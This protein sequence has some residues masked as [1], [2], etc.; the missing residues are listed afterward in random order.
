MLALLSKSSRRAGGFLGR[1][2]SPIGLDLG[3]HAIRAVQLTRAAGASG[4]GETLY[5]IH[6]AAK[7]KRTADPEASPAQFD[8]R[9]AV[10]LKRMLDQGGFKGRKLVMGLDPP[11]LVA[12][13]ISLP[14]K[15]KPLDDP[16]VRSALYFE[17]S[18]HIGYEA[19]EAEIRAWPLPKGGPLA[20]TVM[21]VAARRQVV[22][23]WY[24]LAASAGYSCRRV[25]SGACALVRSCSEFCKP[26]PDSIWGV[27]DVGLLAARLV[28]AVHG[29]PVLQR[30]LSTGG[31]IL[32]YR[33][34]EHLRL[35]PQAAERL[36]VDHGIAGG[37][38][39][40]RDARAPVL[41]ADVSGAAAPS[42]D[43]SS[44]ELD[45]CQVQVPRLIFSAV[46][47][48]LASMAV[49]VEK[50]MAYAM[51]LHGDMPVSMLYLA[52]GGSALKGLADFLAQEVGIEVSLA[53]PLGALAAGRMLAPEEPAPAWARVV[54]LA[55][56][57]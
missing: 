34:A 33:V 16:Q 27:L 12:E 42:G 13:A 24:E 23:N 46:R 11:D 54:G 22:A 2:Y 3:S 49:E 21:G 36:K 8:G 18:R 20:P 9:T 29:I 32:S 10:E 25:D 37:Q 50:S 41:P 44:T 14:L 39:G 6:A 5:R 38:P 15:D 26:P 4:G 53:D 56:L 30:E 19:G 55:L 28:V 31:A 52:G 48:S 35:S 51:H 57:G 47:R 45:P 7:A 40:S 1:G 17:L 43:E